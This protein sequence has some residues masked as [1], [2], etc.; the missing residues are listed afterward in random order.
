MHNTCTDATIEKKGEKTTLVQRKDGVRGWRHGV[1][2]SNPVLAA[3]VAVEPEPN[4]CSGGVH[5]L[6]RNK[7][8]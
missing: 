7:F 5:A 4:Q 2:G 8:E 3:T 1:R 6:F